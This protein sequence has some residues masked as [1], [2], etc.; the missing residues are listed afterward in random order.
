MK[1][2]VKSLTIGTLVLL[3]AA[4]NSSGA[5]EKMTAERL[6]DKSKKEMASSLDAV[7]SHIVYDDYKVTVH[8]G[9]F[10]NP[11]KSGA[12]FDI[13]TDAFLNPMKMHQ[14]TLVQPRGIKSYK[15]NLYRLGDRNFV[16]DENNKEWEEASSETLEKLFGTLVSRSNPTLDLS[17]FDEFKDDFIL[18]PI[19]YGYALTLS[20]NREQFERF[21]QLVPDLGPEQDGF[22]IIYKMDLVITFNKSTSYVTSFKMSADMRSFRDGTSYR[23]RQKLN[24]TYS[25]FNDIDPFKVPDQLQ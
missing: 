9:D 21:K 1:K 19:E 12:K 18:E 2:L 25:Y 6:L 20:L 3:L 24:A 13:Q 23:A 5:T 11:E 7:H 17:L 8:D 22:L 10:E 4:C 15:M 16:S 14:E